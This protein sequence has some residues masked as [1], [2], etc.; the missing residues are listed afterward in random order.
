MPKEVKIFGV[1]IASPSDAKNE[2]ELVKSVVNNWNAEHYET[3][4][5]YEAI[6][7]E[8]HAKRNVGRG[9]DIINEELVD[10]SDLM[11]AIFKNRLG[12]PTGGFMSATL[13]EIDR[14][15]KAGK[16]VCILFSN[17]SSNDTQEYIELQKWKENNAWNGFLTGEFS[18]QQDLSEII[19]QELTKFRP[20]LE[21][22]AT[23]EE[24]YSKRKI[25]ETYTESSSYDPTK[26]KERLRL[27][28]QATLKFDKEHLDSVMKYL[29]EKKGDQP[30]KILDVGCAD[31][32]VTVS[33]FE[34]YENINVLGI[35]ISSK[36]ISR[37]I[38]NNKD[39]TNFTFQELNIIEAESL[40]DTDYDLIFSVYV[41]H[42]LKLSDVVM[43]N[44]WKKLSGNG[45][46]FVRSPDDG[47][48][49]N[50]PEN[51]NLNYLLTTTDKIK[52]SSDRKH[53][54][55]LYTFMKRFED[56]PSKID[57]KYFIDDT[58][59][60]TGDGREHYFSHYYGY[61]NQ[62]IDKL[63]SET[64]LPG[65]IKTAEKINNIMIEQKERFEDSSDVYSFSAAI[66][67]IAYKDFNI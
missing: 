1:F 4:F 55:K 62:E 42:H 17:E 10:K 29:R 56:K 57:L 44:L 20:M 19:R 16:P 26:D 21:G 65:D 30:I 9:Q 15:Q 18:S 38:E 27:Q 40:L 12:T 49:V 46:M 54:R 53:G 6:L 35:D 47:L 37:A 22:G 52:G 51:D 32:T 28:S 3:D 23:A 33:R 60:L 39:K 66:L 25:Q 59:N 48:K 13:E 31:G 58:S 45:V 14:F 63:A 43:N 61:R 41:M 67:A 24:I 50:F 36:Q 5:R 11:I 64:K 34:G 7:W 8:S 2:R